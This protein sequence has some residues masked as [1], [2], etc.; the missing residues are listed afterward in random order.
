MARIAQLVFVI[1]IPFAAGL[2]NQS[3]RHAVAFSEG[4]HNAMTIASLV[5]GVAGLVAFVKVRD[6]MNRFER[7]ASAASKCAIDAP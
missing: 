3:L 6:P 4:F 5:L 7:P 1:V 2:T